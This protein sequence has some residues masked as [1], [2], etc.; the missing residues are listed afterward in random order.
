MSALNTVNNHHGECVDNHTFLIPPPV[1]TLGGHGMPCPYPR[2]VAL[3]VFL[4][5]KPPLVGCV[6]QEVMEQA[7]LA[8]SIL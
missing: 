8:N 1:V 7:G 4:R 3:A 6:N 5:A 2:I